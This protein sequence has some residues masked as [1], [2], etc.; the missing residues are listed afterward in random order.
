MF[1]SPPDRVWA[2]LL[3]KV[4]AVPF[5]GLLLVL[6]ASQIMSLQN[7]SP[8]EAGSGIASSAKILA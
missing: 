5:V 8:E 1:N 6:I 3:F 2:S 7:Y 4:A